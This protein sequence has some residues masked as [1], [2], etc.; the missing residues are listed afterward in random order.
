[1]R[2]TFKLINSYFWKTMYGPILSFIF[3][4]MLLGI[5]GNIMHIEYVYPG[6]IS[7]NILFIGALALPLAFTEFKGSSFFKYIGASPIKP[8]K[9]SLVIVFYYIFISTLSAAIV[10]VTTVGL[11][12]DEVFPGEN[13]K[14]KNGIL[15]GLTTT[16]GF[17][18]FI[19][20][21]LL[22]LLIVIFSGIAIAT[23]SKT[24]QQALT[25]A[26]IIIIPTMFLSGM[27]IT[28][29]IIAQSKTMQM[30]SRFIPFRYSTGNLVISTTPINQLGDI[31]SKLSISEKQV[32]FGNE[33]VVTELGKNYGSVQVKV[34]VNSED[35]TK[36]LEDAKGNTKWASLN[37]E[38][39]TWTGKYLR[40]SKDL[41]NFITD[42]Q[43]KDTKKVLNAQIIF[44]ESLSRE[45]GDFLLFERILLS[46]NALNYSDN[47]I[48]TF[49]EAW[50]VRKLL[51]TTAIKE[52]V[53]DYFR[54]GQIKGAPIDVSRYQVIASKIAN[55]DLRFVDM[56]TKQS[57]QLYTVPERS[58]NVFIPL[59]ITGILGFYITKKFTWTSR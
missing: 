52:F 36:I 8:L 32:I 58:L 53:Q 13:A 19:L 24:P 39:G 28:V 6:I 5:L 56:F 1:M 47:N 40:S 59:V 44:K 50:S 16:S 41:H 17:F 25:L 46:P 27:V 31:F 55:G 48:F 42:I 29:D 26:I 12:N 45:G 33:G 14:F 18:S 20:A 34:N 54:G 2:A 15:G 4:I 38:T 11:F 9:F 51:G 35:L 10:L 43:K 22:H 21:L 30:I 37:E 3:P 57:L 7:L 23:F 49:D